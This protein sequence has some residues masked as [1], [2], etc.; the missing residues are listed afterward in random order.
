MNEVEGHKVSASGSIRPTQFEHAPP[1]A[2]VRALLAV[3]GEDS[4]LHRLAL[5]CARVRRLSAEDQ[6]VVYGE[7]EVPE[8]SGGRACDAED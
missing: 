3:T 1:P 8:V 5:A 7:P 2:V 6:S 4:F